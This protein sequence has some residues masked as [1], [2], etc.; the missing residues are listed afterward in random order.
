MREIKEALMLTDISDIQTEIDD[1]RELV[2][3][4]VG[5]LSILLF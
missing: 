4:M 1:R 2:A 5:T 3:Q